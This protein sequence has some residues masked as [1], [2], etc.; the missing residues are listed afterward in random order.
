VL[1]RLA[2]WV[3]VKGRRAMRRFLFLVF[4]VVACATG[5]AA[6][7]FEDGLSA[8]ERGDYVQAMNHWQPLAAQG[9]AAAQFNLGL[10]YRHGQGVPQDF[11]EALKWY[12]KAA[13]QGH[14]WA[15]FNLGVMYRHGQGAP[16]NAQEAVK[17]YRKAAEQGSAWAQNNLGMMYEVGQGVP[18]DYQEALKWYAR[19]RSRAICRRSSIWVCCMTRDVGFHRTFRKR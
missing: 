6:G 3:I 11:R 18:Q 17:W 9:D 2:L 4:L 16:Q 13:E 10:M 5:A 7:S 8:Y 14:V 1:E 19:Q 15:Q 12:R